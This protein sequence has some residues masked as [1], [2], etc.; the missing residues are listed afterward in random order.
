M[1]VKMILSG[2]ALLVIGLNTIGSTNVTGASGAD[3]T[4]VSGAVIVNEDDYPVRKETRQTF[5]ISPKGAIDVSGIEGAVEV[6]TTSGGAVEMIFVREAMTQTDFDCD[7]INIQTSADSLVI[8]HQSKKEKQ[9]R[10]IRARE[11]LK[12]S[13]P[14]SANLSFNYIEGSFSVGATEG[15]LRL[16]WIEG[17]VKIEQARAAEISWIEGALSLNVAEINSPGINI[18]WIEGSVNLGLNKNLN[19]NLEINSAKVQIESLDT[20]TSS[21]GRKNHQFRLG[22]G[23]ENISISNIENGVKIRG[24]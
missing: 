19:A 16:G 6:E 4:A 3:K 12:L 7:T 23:G 10:I 21:T 8:R 2:I 20:Q 22:A 9:C 14:R 18:N 11:H 13:V 5:Q 1:S 15:L 24:I 17:D